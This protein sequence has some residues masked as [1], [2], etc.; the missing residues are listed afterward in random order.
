MQ[1]ARNTTRTMAVLVTP[2]ALYGALRGAVR[3]DNRDAARLTSAAEMS[4]PRAAHT[5][6]TLIDGRVLVAGGFTTQGSARGAEVFDPASGRYAALPPMVQTR[7]S[8]TATRL[9]DGRVLLAGGYTEGGVPVA[10]A[11]MFDPATN[12]F[13]AAGSLADARADHVATLLAN[14]TVLLAG[15]LGPGWTFLASAELYDPATQRSVRTGTMTDARESH[16]AV[17]LRDGRVLIVGGHRGRREALMLLTS[18]EL[19]DPATGRFT[20][21]GAMRTRRHKHDAVLLADGRVLV[22]GGSDERDDRGVYA[23]TELFDPVSA[24]FAPGAAMQHGRYKHAGTSML[25]PSGL[26]LLGGGAPMA[27]L[28]D[29]IARR[30]SVVPGSTTM[31]GQFSAVALLR[32]GNALITGGYGNGRGPQASSWLFRP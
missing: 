3:T 13:V 6:T 28:Y 25:L 30:F 29:P 31:T 5:A 32:N 4:A 21:T 15:G 19:Y 22:T 8:H 18:A 9:P 23:S 14:G 10:D 17:R 1:I 11:E 7:H 2:L 27:E 26:V 12:T 24:T 16:V 20:R